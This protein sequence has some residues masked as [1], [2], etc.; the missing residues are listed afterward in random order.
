[1]SLNTTMTKVE[2]AYPDYDFIWLDTK[3]HAAF[4]EEQL[5]VPE[6]YLPLVLARTA[7]EPDDKFWYDE[8]PFTRGIKEWIAEI[9]AGNRTPVR[10]LKSD[11]PSEPEA[12][13]I[14]RVVASN[15]EETLK[16]SKG[17]LLAVV[18][19]WCDHCK[20]M[21]PV[22]TQLAQE[23][24]EVGSFSFENNSYCGYEP[25]KDAKEQPVD[26][27]GA[28]DAQGQGVPGLGMTQMEKVCWPAVLPLKNYKPFKWRSVP[29]LF[30]VHPGSPFQPI[31]YDG[32]RSA[33]SIT[34][35]MQNMA[36]R[37][38]EAAKAYA[39]EL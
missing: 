21:K 22:L 19:D 15:L 31:K 28:Q 23:N 20:Q 6:E 26:V 11:E 29:T 9:Q 17:M 25:K 30:Y 34:A 5:D 32:P 7:S 18:A 3:E 13:G 27:D 37:F 33:S 8:F 1:M 2:E 39:A 36:R 38:E 35:F 10:V 14:R 24:I 16:G 12:T 4:V